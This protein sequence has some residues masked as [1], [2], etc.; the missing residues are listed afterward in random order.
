M[1]APVGLVTN[2]HAT[3]DSPMTKFHTTRILGFSSVGA[4]LLAGYLFLSAMATAS[5]RFWYCGPTSLDHV[6]PTCR[7]GTKLLLASWVTAAAAVLLGV[8]TLWFHVRYRKDA[9]R[10]ARTL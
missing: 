6:D 8:V 10:S 3:P 4:A 1:A 5:G 2:S 9:S 7:I